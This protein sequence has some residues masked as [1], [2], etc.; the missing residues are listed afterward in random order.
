MVGIGT[1]PILCWHIFGLF[2]TLLLT[3]SA[4]SNGRQ[5]KWPFSEPIESRDSGTKG[6]NVLFTLN[7]TTHLT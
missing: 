3:I 1:I 5:Q 2:L 6:N 4:Y 7:Q